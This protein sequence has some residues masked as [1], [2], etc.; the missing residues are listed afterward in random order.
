MP[1]IKKLFSDYFHAWWCRA[2]AMRP[3]MGN[4]YELFA[5]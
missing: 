4:Y 5:D 2:R 3:Y 1:K